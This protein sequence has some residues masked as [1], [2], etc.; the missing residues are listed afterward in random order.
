MQNTDQYKI[1]E[2]SLVE[3][4]DRLNIDIANKFV[5]LHQEV[6]P[7]QKSTNIIKSCPSDSK[8]MII[9]DKSNKTL[10]FLIYLKLCEEEYEILDIGIKQEYRNKG[11][12]TKMLEK[13]ENALIE[14]SKS[15]GQNKVFL[16]VSAQNLSAIG[17]YEKKGFIKY[18]TRKNYYKTAKNYQDAILYSKII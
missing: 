11:Y 10:G 8:L 13:F 16:E 6:F 12:A 9:M 17:L 15:E 4:M 5:L 14:Q 7:N 18:G 1:I 2:I 3:L